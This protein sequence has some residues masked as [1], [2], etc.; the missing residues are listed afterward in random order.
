M[1]PVIRVSSSR[2]TGWARSPNAKP[3]MPHMLG[4]PRARSVIGPATHP[5]LEA[6]HGP[7]PGRT[8]STPGLVR[9]QEPFDP[10]RSEDSALTRARIQQQVMSHL[11]QLAAEPGSQRHAEAHLPTRENLRRESRRHGLLEYVFA[12]PV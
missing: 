9:A 2:S 7:K 8:V 3:A 6:E 1:T 11:A 10:G 4:G 5:E 12:R